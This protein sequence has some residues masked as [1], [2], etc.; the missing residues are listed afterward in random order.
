MLNLT[1][2]RSVW[3]PVKLDLTKKVFILL[4]VQNKSQKVILY[5]GRGGAGAHRKGAAQIVISGSCYADWK[6]APK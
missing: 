1:V 5:K 3:Y 4:F 2:V 6:T